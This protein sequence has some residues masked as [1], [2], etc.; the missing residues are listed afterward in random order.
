MNDLFGL[1]SPLQQLKLPVWHFPFRPAIFVSRPRARDLV[2]IGTVSLY[3][4]ASL[5][6]M[7]IPSNS[8]SCS[9]CIIPAF[10]CLWCYN[11]HVYF[12]NGPSY[13]CTYVIMSSHYNEYKNLQYVPMLFPVL[14][15]CAA[16]MKDWDEIS[17]KHQC[18]V[19]PCTVL[20]VR[21]GLGNEYK[22]NEK[23]EYLWFAINCMVLKIGSWN[24]IHKA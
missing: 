3:C 8:V 10:V 4:L 21:Q 12:L 5:E 11:S 2:Y 6:H 13:E 20:L 19:F 9:L 17:G 7:H 1:P 14:W 15:I 16:L 23:R 22:N 24:L 18:N